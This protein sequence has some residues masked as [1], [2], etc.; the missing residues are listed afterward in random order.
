MN[1][2]ILVILTIIITSLLLRFCI[3]SQIKYFPIYISV[4]NHNK[5]L[6]AKLIRR[7]I[8]CL[9]LK[10]Y[11]AHACT[12]VLYQSQHN[13]ICVWNED[14]DKSHFAAITRT[15]RIKYSRTTIKLSMCIKSLHYII[16]H[17]ILYPSKYLI[18]CC[19]DEL[20]LHIPCSRKKNTSFTETYILG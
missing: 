19:M 9:L 3:F 16:E 2:N 13:I 18:L 8:T 14:N 7:Y 6:I 12:H 11:V 1:N 5:Y 20:L 15:V 10:N 4:S 17:L